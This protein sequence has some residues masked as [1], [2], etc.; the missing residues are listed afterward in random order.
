MR[1][2]VNAGRELIQLLRE[3]GATDWI[4]WLLEAFAL[5][6][7]DPADPLDA[8]ARLRLLA[9]GRFPDGQPIWDQLSTAEVDTLSVFAGHAVDGAVRTAA[10]RWLDWCRRTLF[11]PVASESAWSRDRFE[12]N[13]RLTAPRP[14]NTIVLDAVEHLGGPIDWFSFNASIEPNGDP[15]ATISTRDHTLVPTRVTFRGMPNP[16]WWELEDAAIDLGAVE[17]HPGDLARLALL[18][19]GLVYG[20]DH[21]IVPVQLDVGHVCRTTDLLVTDTFGMTTF[22]EP[23]HRYAQQDQRWTMFTLH[24]EDSAATGN[25]F[26]L[27]PSSPHQLDGPT[28]EEVALLRDEMANL[29]WA[30]ERYFEGED[31]LPVDRAQRSR[32]PPTTQPP[33]AGNPTRYRLGT[34]VPPYWFPLVPELGT[35]ARRLRVTEMAYST[36]PDAEPKGHLITLGQLIEDEELPREGL[37][38]VRDRVLARWT[39]GTPVAWT[40]HR[41]RIGRGEGSS[42]LRFDIVET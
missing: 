6:P 28:V 14:D 34:T 32:R 41:T 7:P 30:V 33:S 42:G 1:Q 18:D 3:A 27:P 12:Y 21:F 25:V 35:A 13:F 10:R 15:T 29:A 19:F 22:V 8:G 20:N 24:G 9:A 36:E 17:A 31:G 39:D 5:K 23:A 38:L 11:E 2:R 4:E 37:H 26:V 16:R 40:R